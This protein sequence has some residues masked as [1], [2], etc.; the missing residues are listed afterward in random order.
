MPSPASNC[1]IPMRV[2]FSQRVT[3]RIP[4]STWPTT[5]SGSTSSVWKPRKSRFLHGI[6]RCSASM[7]GSRGRVDVQSSAMCWRRAGRAKTIGSVD[8]WIARAMSI[9]IGWPTMRNTILCA[10]GRRVSGWC[11]LTPASTW[12]YTTT[13]FDAYSRRLEAHTGS[14]LKVQ[15]AA[16][17]YWWLWIQLIYKVLIQC[18]FWCYAY[19]TSMYTIFAAL[20]VLL[21][22]LLS[23]LRLRLSTSAS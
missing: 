16:I 17:R 19:E 8:G 6:C 15:Q 9:V 5:S 12:N 10:S 11:A 20:H 23:I 13:S 3:Q 7:F 4:H 2:L 21:Y 18:A 22:Q 14:C 1:P